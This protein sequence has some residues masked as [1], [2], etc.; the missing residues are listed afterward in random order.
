ME[1]VL[2]N[3]FVKELYMFWIQTVFVKVKPEAP[4]LN[5]NQKTLGDFRAAGN[6][7]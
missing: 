2:I 5:N 1:S 7:R 6:I 3:P 4:F